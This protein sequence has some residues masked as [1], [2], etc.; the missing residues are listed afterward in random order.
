MKLKTLKDFSEFRF[1]YTDE[2]DPLIHIKE[3]KA[4]AVK[5]VKLKE[6]RLHMIDWLEF[7]NITEEDLK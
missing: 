6:E 5:W 3:L 7:F 1:D 4:E 2:D